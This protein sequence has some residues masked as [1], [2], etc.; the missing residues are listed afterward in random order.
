MRLSAPGGR[1][2]SPWGSLAAQKLYLGKGPP[3]KGVPR[4]GY[5]PPLPFRKNFEISRANPFPKGK[6]FG[7]I[8]RF[9]DFE[10]SRANTS[11]KGKPFGGISYFEIS[12][13]NTSPKGKPLGEISRFRGQTLPLKGNPS[14]IFPQEDP[15][16]KTYPGRGPENTPY[17]LAAIPPSGEVSA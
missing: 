2:L 13:A 8:S 10:I 14:A 17:N 11:P 5:P 12:R 16:G 6:P 9:R 7:E 3:C 4:K 15:S 1:N